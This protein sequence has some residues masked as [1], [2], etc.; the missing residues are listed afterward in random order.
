MNEENANVY[1]ALADAE[2]IDIVHQEHAEPERRTVSMDFQMP[3]DEEA[4]TYLQQMLSQS[5][6]QGQF[7]G[8]VVAM[9]KWLDELGDRL[10]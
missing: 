4:K 2:P 6:M 3:T 9:S 5:Q 1:P 10:T 7:A 8:N